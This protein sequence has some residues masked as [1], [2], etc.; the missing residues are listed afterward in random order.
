MTAAD[1]IS[2]FNRGRTSVNGRYA[3]SMATE[4][5]PYYAL[6]RVWEGKQPLFVRTLAVTL[7][8]ALERAAAMLQNCNVEL[9]C[10]DNSFFESGYG[11]TD[12][13]MPF[14][15][16]RGKRMA[17]VFYV[18][19]S[20][21]LWLANKFTPDTDRFDKLIAMA[22]QFAEVHFELT[23]SKRKISSVS[24]Y[25]G[26]KG[27]KLRDVFVTVINIRR[28]VDTYKPDFYVDL[29][30]LASDRDGNRC[31][32]LIKAGGRSLSPNQVSCHTRKVEVGE[33]LHIRSCKVM[34][35][36]ESHGVR[37]TRLG[38]CTFSLP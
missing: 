1:M 34:A 17:E 4:F 10:L 30:I 38:Y 12:D 23:V 18:D 25:V 15:K 7:Q 33:V 9:V 14:G 29:N 8:A 32:F 5:R 2:N 20:Y 21:V 37:Y 24:N 26:E 11:R 22:R 36:F 31:V 16:Y 19:P 35:H 3:I 13:I 6:W 27:D 28:Q